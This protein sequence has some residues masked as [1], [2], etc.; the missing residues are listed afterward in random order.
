MPSVNEYISSDKL[1]KNNSI[2]NVAKKI[3]SEINEEFPSQTTVIINI[4][5]YYYLFDRDNHSEFSI[6][7]TT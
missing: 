7:I 6:Q 5:W 1:T 3:T 4:N 2:K